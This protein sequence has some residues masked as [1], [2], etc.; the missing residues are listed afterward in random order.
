M[1]Q[2]TASKISQSP[3]RL[4]AALGLVPAATI[5]LAVVLG[6]Q[7][8]RSPVV[9]QGRAACTLILLI[10]SGSQVALVWRA[11]RSDR[12]IGNFPWRQFAKAGLVL[13]TALA[14]VAFVIGQ[15]R[16]G[17]FVLAVGL[18]SLG[19]I[20]LSPLAAPAEALELWRRLAGECLARSSRRAGACDATD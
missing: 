6:L 2:V 20:I 14:T 5:A 15:S 8:F 17:Q 18:A 19:A 1:S 3:V 4:I 16:G 13:V 7:H 10:L 11:A 9:V 12:C